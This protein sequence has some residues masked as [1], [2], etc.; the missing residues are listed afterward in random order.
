MV[1]DDGADDVCQRLVRLEPG[2]PAAA[3][4]DLTLF[5]RRTAPAGDPRLPEWLYRALE[6]RAASFGGR[7]GRILYDLDLLSHESKGP[8]ALDAC[9]VRMIEHE[10]DRVD[11]FAN[12]ALDEVPF[13]SANFAAH[14]A[15]NMAE[16]SPDPQ[17][18]A[19]YLN[20]ASTYLSAL[21]RREGALTCAQQAAGLYRE[22]ARARPEAF[23]PD[24]AMSLNNLAVMLSELGRRQKALTCAQQAAGLYRELA[25]ARPEPFTPNLALSLSNFA[26]MLSALG[27]REEALTCAQGAVAIRRELARARPKAFTP[28]LAASLKN[29]AIFLSELGRHQEALAISEE[30][31][32]L[33]APDTAT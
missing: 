26:V 19:G 1:V 21:G 14:V 6:E 22:L 33:L 24:L 10:P 8:H 31:K 25:R 18:K 7:L 15:V 11:L 29:L 23:T 4:L 3:F 5:D 20:N 27:L 32:R 9:L 12:V 30:R 17:V 2:R 13:A 28:V 16:R